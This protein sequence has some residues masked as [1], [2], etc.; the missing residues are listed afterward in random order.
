MHTCPGGGR[1]ARALRQRHNG[2]LLCRAIG[3]SIL[4]NLDPFLFSG[5]SSCV[6]EVDCFVRFVIGIPNIFSLRF[7]FSLLSPCNPILAVQPLKS[8]HPLGGGLHSRRSRVQVEERTGQPGALGD[9]EDGRVP[10]SLERNQFFPPKNLPS[11]FPFFTLGYIFWMLRAEQPPM[12]HLVPVGE[13]IRMT[14]IC[15]DK[16]LG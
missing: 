5:V 2:S 8:S 3:F 4:W 10:N 7:S 9:G 15:S 14:K 16:I 13:Q 1:E 6:L 12:W 11:H